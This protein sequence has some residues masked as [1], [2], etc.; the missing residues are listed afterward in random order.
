MRLPGFVRFDAGL[1]A[2]ID[3]TWSAAQYREHL[4][5][6]LLA[7]GDGNNISPGQGRTIRLS[8]RARFLKGFIRKRSFRWF[9]PPDLVLQRGRFPNHRSVLGD[10]DRIAE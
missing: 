8:A 6:G 5:Q 2:K 9:W 1:F 10:Y 4:Q 7:T 3:E